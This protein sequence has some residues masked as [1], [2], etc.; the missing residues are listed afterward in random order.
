MEYQKLETG[1]GTIIIKDAE[2]PEL[3]GLIDVY[4]SVF[5]KHIIFEKAPE[6]IL[7]YLKKSHK[8]NEGVGGGYII[9]KLGDKIIGGILV[10]KKGGGLETNHTLW[11]Y[12]HVALLTDYSKLRIG[13]ALINAADKKIKELIKQGRIKTAKIELGVSENEKDALNFFKK[14]GF[15]IE[16]KLKSHFRLN[17]AVYIIGKEITE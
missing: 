6:E 3:E 15:E 10:R 11:I 13:S 4:R 9:A 14:F 17:E 2:D 7:E 8:K 5:K 16:G 12:N 1:S